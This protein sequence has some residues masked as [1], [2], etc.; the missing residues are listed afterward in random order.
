M[1]T[2]LIL[3]I[4]IN[5]VTFLLISTFTTKLYNQ[6]NNIKYYNKKLILKSDKLEN[7]SPNKTLLPPEHEIKELNISSITNN[8][9]LFQSFL[10]MTTNQLKNI[11]TDIQKEKNNTLIANSNLF[12]NLLNATSN[13]FKSINAAIPLS[14]TPTLLPSSSSSSSIKTKNNYIKDNEVNDLKIRIDKLEKSIVTLT[15]NQQQMFT[16]NQLTT[17]STVTDLMDAFNR[18]QLAMSPRN[19]EICSIISF[20]FIGIVIGTSLFDRLWLLGTIYMFLYVIY[21]TIIYTM[22]MFPL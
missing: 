12:Q 19:V 10:N 1:N 21:H 7:W 17:K 16:T 2:F 22:F 8:N 13:Q 3:L 4:L 14:N 5:F 11:E 9:N 6:Q 20:F 18:G 15:T